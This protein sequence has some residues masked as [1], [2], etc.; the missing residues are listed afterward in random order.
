[1][2]CIPLGGLVEM[3][4]FKKFKEQLDDKKKKQEHEKLIQALKQPEIQ[5]KRP[6]VKFANTGPK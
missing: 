1:M 5:R 2:D 3:K 4:L 6:A